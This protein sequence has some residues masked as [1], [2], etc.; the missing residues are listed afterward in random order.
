MLNLTDK[1]QYQKVSAF[2]INL[3]LH[4]ISAGKFVNNLINNISKVIVVIKISKPS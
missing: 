4:E 2:V 3:S 1:S